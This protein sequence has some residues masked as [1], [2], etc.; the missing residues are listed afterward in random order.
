[1]EFLAREIS[2]IRLALEHKADREDVV[3]AVDRLTSVLERIP[4]A[5]G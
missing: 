1:M 5:S 2:G 3:E 4:G